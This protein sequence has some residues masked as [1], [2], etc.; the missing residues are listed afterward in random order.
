M[1]YT[2]EISRSNPSC[3][4]FLIDQSGS[5][6]DEYKDIL[7]R[8]SK[9]QALADVINRL[10]QQLVIKCAKGDST[11]PMGVRDYYYIG[12]IGYGDNGAGPAFGGIHSGKEL[13]SISSIANNPV[14]IEE[15]NK[16]QSDGAGGL[17]DTTVKF[18]IWFDSTA[19]GGTPMTEAFKKAN[20]IISNWLSK[21]PNCFPPVVINITDGASTDGD[22][23]NEMERL[24][25]QSSNDGNVILF[26]LHT[27]T[28][29]TNPLTFPGTEASLP[30][31]YSKML[32]NGSSL[33]PDFMKNVASNE[34]SINLS[35]DARA[36]ILNGNID[37]I[38]TAIEI[39]TRPSLQLR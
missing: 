28:S 27:H 17:V 1:S 36:F 32:F 8:K 26:N 29:G 6:S 16:K 19:E 12:V 30:D 5:M 37:V 18:P 23:L 11:N 25:N 15:R 22:P 31:Q 13:V 39:G 38:I 14:R 4:L 9:A 34:F 7:P 33:L 2:A 10:L 35:N 24:K 20:D 3:F 21:N